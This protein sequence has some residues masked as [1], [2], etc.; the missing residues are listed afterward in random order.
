MG[1]RMYMYVSTNSAKVDIYSGPRVPLII[2][3]IV[4][5]L[6][7]IQLGNLFM[8]VSN[9]DLLVPSF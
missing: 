7:M 1:V 2:Y 9:L 3:V 5:R 4:S 8:S 6:A